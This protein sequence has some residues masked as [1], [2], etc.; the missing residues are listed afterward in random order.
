MIKL[1]LIIVSSF[2]TLSNFTLLAQGPE[3]CKEELSNLK[4]S[5]PFK[6]NSDLTVQSVNPS[7][8]RLEINLDWNSPIKDLFYEGPGETYFISLEEMHDKL[9]DIL[10]ENGERDLLESIVIYK[11]NNK[12]VLFNLITKEDGE[13]HS[14]L[15]DTEGNLVNVSYDDVPEEVFE[16]VTETQIEIIERD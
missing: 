15:V 1:F 12:E 3:E 8:D 6:V 9:I 2:L 5:T 11:R 10:D 13:K 4:K 16:T 14:L 7:K